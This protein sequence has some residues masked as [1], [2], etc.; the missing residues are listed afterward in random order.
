MRIGFLKTGNDYNFKPENVKLFRN[1]TRDVIKTLNKVELRYNTRVGQPNYPAMKSLYKWRSVFGYRLGGVIRQAI[2]KFSDI[3]RHKENAR[4]LREALAEA[5]MLKKMG[6]EEV[7]PGSGGESDSVNE[8]D[9][10]AKNPIDKKGDVKTFDSKKYEEEYSKLDNYVRKYSSRDVY[11]AVKKLHPQDM[12]TI[13]Y[14]KYQKFDEIHESGHKIAAG[15]DFSVRKLIVDSWIDSHKPKED[16]SG[17]R[18]I[19]EETKKNLEIQNRRD[20]IIFNENKQEDFIE[21]KQKII[22]YELRQEKREEKLELLENNRKEQLNNKL[23]E[24][25]VEEGISIDAIISGM[26]DEDIAYFKDGKENQNYTGKKLSKEEWSDLLN[27]KK[28]EKDDFHY[29]GTGVSFDTIVLGMKKQPKLEQIAYFEDGSKNPEYKGKEVTKEKWKDISEAMNNQLKLEQIAYFK[30]GRK[31][32]EYIGKKVTNEEWKVILEEMKEEMKTDHIAYFEDGKKNLKYKGNEISKEE[33][34]NLLAE[35]KVVYDKLIRT[36]VF[37]NGERN[38]GYIGPKSRIPK[39][40]TKDVPEVVQKPKKLM[41]R[42]MSDEELIKNYPAL[43]Q[44]AERKFEPKKPFISD[45][46]LKRAEDAQNRE[47]RFGNLSRFVHGNLPID[48]IERAG[49]FIRFKLDFK[50]RRANALDAKKEFL[51]MKEERNQE[52]P[53]EGMKKVANKLNW[54]GATYLK[55]FF[56]TRVWRG[57]ERFAKEETKEFLQDYRRKE[58]RNLG[59]GA[60]LTKDSDDSLKSD[61]KNV[62]F[63]RLGERGETVGTEFALKDPTREDTYKRE[64]VQVR[65]VRSMPERDISERKISDDNGSEESKM[66]QID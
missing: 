51:S 62:E 28:E 39:P 44:I 52:S 54:G 5:K 58:L 59:L 47:D 64:D 11:R 22:D 33:W 63:G 7:K 16:W 13:K 27:K 42:D 31:N 19:H 48:R 4:N 14:L 2:V 25:P 1:E 29:Y 38:W 56:E 8:I 55:A 41:A 43:R 50:D 24:E 60:P 65:R 61:L 36:P 34:T 26:K 57:H 37:E 53:P 20:E 40:E 3:S 30:D 23:K 10:E 18:Q 32:P 17:M 35:Q 15:Q 46:T 66:D 49:K 21:V 12:S 9:I 45:E 6:G